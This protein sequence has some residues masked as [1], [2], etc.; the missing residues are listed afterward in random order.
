MD[1]VDAQNG[2]LSKKVASYPGRGERNLP[3]PHLLQWKGMGTVMAIFQNMQVTMKTAAVGK[4]F[5]M[6]TERP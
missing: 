4:A 5:S 6:R 2:L 1:L 3:S